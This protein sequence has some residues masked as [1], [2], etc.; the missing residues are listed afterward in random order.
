MNKQTYTGTVRYVYKDT[1]GWFVRFTTN[2]GN[3]YRMRQVKGL[4]GAREGDVVIVRAEV[5]TS[6]GDRW[7]YD[8]MTITTLCKS[9]SAAIIE[10]QPA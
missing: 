2:D 10:R 7:L 4:H 6:E 9:T 1:N 5:S 8:H 3:V